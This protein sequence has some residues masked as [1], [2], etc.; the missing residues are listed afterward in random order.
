MRRRHAPTTVNIFASA[1]TAAI[2][3][4]AS[5]PNG[6]RI[7]GLQMAGIGDQMDMDFVPLRVVYSP[8]APMWYFTSPVP[9]TLRGSTSS[10]PAKISS[11]ARFAMWTITLRRPRWLMPITSSVAPRLDPRSRISSTSGISAV[12]PSREKRLLPR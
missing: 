6:D 5:R 11:G 1:F 7:D 9:R 8:V 2:L 12:T 3:F 10:N 4:C